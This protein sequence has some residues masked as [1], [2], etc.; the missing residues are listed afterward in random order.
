LVAYPNPVK[1]NDVAFRYQLSMPAD[2]VHF[3]LFTT[4]FRKVVEFEGSAHAGDNEAVYNVSGLANGLYY[5]VIEVEA[6]GNPS[7]SSG[8]RRERKIGKLI[9]TR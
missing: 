7:S 2:Q 3:K 9:I 4:A 8:Q 5:Y 6:G 1:E